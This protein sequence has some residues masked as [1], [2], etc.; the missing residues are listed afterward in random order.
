MK[1]KP[2]TQLRLHGK[3]KG[4]LPFIVLL[5]LLVR[6]TPGHADGVTVITHGANPSGASS[7]TWMA[8]MRDAIATNFLGGAQHYGTITVTGA[9]G[10]LVAKCGPW[11]VNLSAG[12][13][14]D[15]IIVLDWSA[16]ASHTTTG[17]SAQSVAATV[18]DKIVTGQ[19]GQRPLAES[20]I[21]LVGHSR[22]GGLVCELARLLGER[23]VVVDHLTPLDPH[24][25]TTNDPQVAAR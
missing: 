7:P 21:H 6:P 16:V 25:L 19:N 22:G 13:S 3:T 5:G 18:V 4:V 2:S 24:P 12:S 11:N 17:V 9:V 20:P 23:G 1:E 14:S 8:S 10:A 15:L